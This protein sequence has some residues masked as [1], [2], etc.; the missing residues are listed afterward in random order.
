[1]RQEYMNF[2]PQTIRAEK[3]REKTEEL[4]YLGEQ[5][6]K[7]KKQYHY[8]EEDTKAGSAFLVAVV[9]GGA[10]GLV[11][12]TCLC[13]GTGMM[14]ETGLIPL[15]CFFGAPVIGI[16][17]AYKAIHVNGRKKA[18]L[19]S[20]AQ[21]VQNE[22][23]M[24]VAKINQEVDAACREFQ[25]GFEREVCA[26]IAEFSQPPI[27]Q[28]YIRI[29]AKELLSKI[30]FQDRSKKVRSIEVSFAMRVYA[31]KVCTAANE[32]QVMDALFKP[33]EGFAEEM[34]M[35]RSV[36]SAVQVELMTLL[37]ADPSGSPYSVN[38]RESYELDAAVAQIN[39]RA[40]NQNY[41]EIKNW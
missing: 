37:P 40:D 16:I 35:A 23:D 32:Y 19:E 36:A 3:M 8:S 24:A 15:S 28:I 27:D 10:L 1:M 22:H 6:E 17:I 34:A 11:V 21:R 29:F 13:L 30:Q 12:G 41:E 26:K 2:N 5:A 20:G 31:D 14:V 39:Y 18:K 9:S 25:E 4:K 7:K 38:I 33:L